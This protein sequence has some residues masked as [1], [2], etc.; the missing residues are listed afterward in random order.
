MQRLLT[1]KS[2]KA[3]QNA[4]W[5]NWPILSALS[6]TTS[7]SGLVI[8]YFYQKCDP[9]L[10]GRITSRDQNMAIY[11]TDALGHVPGVAGNTHIFIKVFELKFLL[12]GLFVSGIFSASLSTVSSCLNSLAAVT[13]EDYMKP[14]YLYA[15]KRPLEISPSI[16]AA[17]YGILCIGTAFLAQEIGGILQVSLTIFGVVGGPLL[18]IFTL[19]MGTN[20]NEKGSIIG[21]FSGMII[22][23]WIGFGGPKPSPKVRSMIFLYLQVLIPFFV[24]QYLTFSTEDCSQF[25]LHNITQSIPDSSSPTRDSE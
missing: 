2:L 6:L 25:N 21:L 23:M 3:A 13:I 12:L 18:G 19:G 5:W 4:L 1:V 15:T 9:L 8:Y 22:S 11:I 10:S 20:A 17:F 14:L 16:V 24:F 7:F